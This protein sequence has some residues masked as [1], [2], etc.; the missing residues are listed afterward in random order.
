MDIKAIVSEIESGD[1]INDVAK[2]HD[3][4]ADYIHENLSAWIAQVSQSSGSEQASRFLNTA[5]SHLTPSNKLMQVLPSATKKLE[6]HDVDGFF[7]DVAPI[8]A[9]QL[10]KDSIFEPNAKVRNAA[11]KDILDRA[12]YKPVQKLEVYAKYDRMERKELI[13]AIRGA[14]MSNPEVV[15]QLAS[16]SEAMKAEKQQQS[17]PQEIIDAEVEE[18]SDD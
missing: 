4:T 5:D 7:E 12:G 1:H 3:I 13:G 11:Q 6:N 18:I 17:Q 15:H 10:A 8:V 14:L 9:M 2:R 16:M